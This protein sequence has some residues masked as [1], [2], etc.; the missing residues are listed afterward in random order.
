MN[1]L[2]FVKVMGKNGNF[3]EPIYMMA[4]NICADGIYLMSDDPFPLNTY[5][6]I[7]FFIPTRNP[8]DTISPNDKIL[9]LLE[10][11]GRVIRCERNGMAIQFGKK[12]RI[13]PLIKRWRREKPV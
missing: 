6:H 8:I 4:S 13:V 9:S 10:T 5:V 11:T 2:S 1:L 12:C 3:S 7:G